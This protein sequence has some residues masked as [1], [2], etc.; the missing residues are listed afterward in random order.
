MPDETKI[1]I[2]ELKEF[3]L[4]P[5]KEQLREIKIGMGVNPDLEG[6]EVAKEFYR[7]NNMQFDE[8]KYLQSHIDR[9]IY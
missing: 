5:T 1:E 2:I 7:I 4:R 3:P 9:I 6:I 8:D